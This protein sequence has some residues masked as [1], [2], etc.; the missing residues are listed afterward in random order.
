MESFAPD[1]PNIWAGIEQGVQA[2]A[3]AQTATVTKIIASK[4]VISIA[5]IAAILVIPASVVV[6]FVSN[7]KNNVVENKKV[8]NINITPNKDIEDLKTVE[9]PKTASINIENKAIKINENKRAFSNNNSNSNT[10]EKTANEIVSI[11]KQN[12]SEQINN[13][14]KVKNEKVVLVSN[15]T[16]K[17]ISNE[18]I[19]ENNEVSLIEENEI[20]VDFSN[21]GK[22]SGIRVFPNVFTPNNDGIDDKYV[23]DL[24]G[25]KFYNLKIYNYNNELVFESNDKNN[26]WDG[27]NY[28]NGQACNSGTYFGIF[29]FK[30]T[31]EDKISTRMTKIKLIR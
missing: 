15:E 27:L 2:N 28:K 9:T 14:N 19:A 17:D 25:E 4:L 26:N 30:L 24:E 18:E 22:E 8:E 20:K 21:V 16:N 13:S 23:I 29:E 12:T 3:T 5:K 10:S 31:N 11:N 1:A 7:E 6:Y